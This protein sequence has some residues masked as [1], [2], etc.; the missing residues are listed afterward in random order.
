MANERMPGGNGRYQ[1]D[2]PPIIFG[3]D[4]VDLTWI[5]IIIIGIWGFIGALSGTWIPLGGLSVFNDL[6]RAQHGVLSMVLAARGIFTFFDFYS[7]T[8]TVVTE[9]IL[10]LTIIFGMPTMVNKLADAK[11]AA[12]RMTG[13]VVTEIEARRPSGRSS[14]DDNLRATNANDSI[15]FNPYLKKTLTGTQVAWC[16]DRY[17]ERNFGDVTNTQGSVVNIGRAC[18]YHHPGVAWCRQNYDQLSPDGKA[19]CDD[20]R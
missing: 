9:I 10:A 3:K 4:W 14:S 5:V 7:R 17:N 19:S 2:W 1:K 13:N 11:L 12:E 15:F 16:K 6:D 20:E 18:G 8:I